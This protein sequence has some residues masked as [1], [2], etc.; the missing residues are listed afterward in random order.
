MR[1]LRELSF[2]IKFDDERGDGRCQV[3][4]ESTV[5]DIDGDGDLRIVHRGETHENR[6]VGTRIFDR[7]RLA[8][9]GVGGLDARRR[10]TFNGQSHTIDDGRIGFGCDF[11]L[12]LRQI[13]LR[14]WS[15]FRSLMDVR[16]NSLWTKEKGIY[17]D[18]PKT[19]GSIRMLKIPVEL[20]HQLQDYKRWQEDYKASLGSKW[21]EHDRLFTKWDGSPMSVRAPYKY[22][23]YFCKRHKIRFCKEEAS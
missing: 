5:F 12:S 11:R 13:A 14:K 1:T 20:V 7:S 23:E 19:K 3:G 15:I 16:R 6:V 10:P 17:T 21:T 18:T 8:A 22:F 9:N 2:Q 4:T